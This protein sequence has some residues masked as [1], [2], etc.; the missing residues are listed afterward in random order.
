MQDSPQ[1]VALQRNCNNDTPFKLI[2]ENLGFVAEC[3]PAIR[4]GDHEVLNHYVEDENEK[5]SRV[6]EF[7]KAINETLT[8]EKVRA[9]YDKVTLLHD[10]AE[11]LKGLIAKAAYINE[12]H[13][14]YE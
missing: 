11:V 14:A 5:T 2:I 6:E 1:E 9:L 4:Y 12:I 3:L 7:K 8:I 10:H 13:K